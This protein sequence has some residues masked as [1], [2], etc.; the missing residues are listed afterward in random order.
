VSAVKAAGFAVTREAGE[1][2]DNSNC[3]WQS[4]NAAPVAAQAPGKHKARYAAVIA[5]I[6]ELHRLF[7]ADHAY[8]CDPLDLLFERCCTL[9]DRVD[10]SELAFL[11][12]VDMAWTAAEFAGTVDRVGPD[13]I[14]HVLACA[15]MHSRRDA[16]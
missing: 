14:Q 12:A 5:V 6:S 4:S 1:I 13:Q 7:P 11:D 10:A 9:A 15:F 2:A 8:P 3:D 16:A